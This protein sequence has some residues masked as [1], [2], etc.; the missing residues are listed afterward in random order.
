MR[1]R[2]IARLGAGA[3]RQIALEQ[4]EQ[5]RREALKLQAPA[6]PV[7]KRRSKFGNVPVTLHGHRFA[8]QAEGRY[9][10][11]LRE[12]EA[13]GEIRELVCQPKYPM[14]IGGICIGHY[15]ADFEY[16][17]KGERVV[18]DVKGISTPVFRLKKRIIEALYDFKITVVKV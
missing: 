12:R 2:D 11:R 3:R 16:Y 4:L 9:Y 15:I 13:R 7:T 10:L 17:Q 1:A 8:S 6:K 5:A 14:V 18:V